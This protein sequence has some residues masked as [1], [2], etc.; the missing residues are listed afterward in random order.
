MGLLRKNK[1]YDR[2]DL[3]AAAAKAQARGKI[4]KAL[5][6]YLDVLRIEPKNAELHRK[7]A[8][9]LARVKEIDK[10]WASFS[11]AAEALANEGFLDKAIGVYREAA[12]YVPGK[13]DAWMAIAELHAQRDRKAAA[14][15]ALLEGRLQLKRR[16]DRPAA[17]RLLSY[18]REIDPHNFEVGVDLARLLRKSGQ[19]KRAKRLLEEIKRYSHRG[20]LAHLRKTELRMSPTPFA[21]FRW[22]FAFITRS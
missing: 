6:L 19:R 18:A 5:A 15:E 9:L 4:K 21:L 10:A 16:R 17:I 2:A 7:V 8:P 14:V 22:L 11:I 1:A 3:M 20:Q 12:H 13:T